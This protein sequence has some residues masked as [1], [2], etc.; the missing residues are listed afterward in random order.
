M[1]EVEKTAYRLYVLPT[2]PETISYAEENERF[3]RITPR[4]ALIYTSGEIHLRHAEITSAEIK[5]LSDADMSWLRDCNLALLAEAAR[6][7]EGA[8]AQDMSNRLDRLEAAL[9]TEA[10]K[11]AKEG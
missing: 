9:K 7:N 4:Y 10:E 1:Q 2:E 8:I 11:Q 6:E 3:Y 5:R